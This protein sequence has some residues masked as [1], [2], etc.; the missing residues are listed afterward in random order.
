MIYD[1]KNNL[2][3]DVKNAKIL[4]FKILGFTK[5]NIPVY[6]IGIFNKLP[7]SILK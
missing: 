5:I 6:G 4:R 7:E 2:L 1:K 3:K